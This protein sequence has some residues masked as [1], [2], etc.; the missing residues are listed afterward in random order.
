MLLAMCWM[1][2]V[3][4]C[5]LLEAC[6]TN[7]WLWWSHK[8]IREQCFFLNIFCNI[9]LCEGDM[10]IH[11]LHQW[12]PEYWCCSCIQQWICEC[13]SSSRARPIPARASVAATW[14]LSLEQAFQSW[15]WQTIWTA[16][17]VKQTYQAR[18]RVE[19]EIQRGDAL[20]RRSSSWP[21]RRWWG[22]RRWS[23]G[24]PPPGP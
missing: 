18:C 10:S 2:I 24:R 20:H 13:S 23:P 22:C 5:L 11:S 4:R 19:D 7:T 8:M 3:L 15:I 12:R 9:Y 17:K 1:L 16:I 21:T 14:I 6:S